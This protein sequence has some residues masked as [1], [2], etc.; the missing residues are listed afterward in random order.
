ML[1]ARL[2]EPEFTLVWSHSVEKTRWIERYRVE[3]RTLHLVEASVEGSGAGMEPGPGAVLSDGAWR[4][5]PDRSVTEL[6]LRRS[7]FA[8]DYAICAGGACAL[9]GRWAG[10]PGLDSVVTIRPCT[11]GAD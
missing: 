3:A 6:V 7:G 5:H 11:V 10:R 8:E 2:P 1:V 4:W 9:L